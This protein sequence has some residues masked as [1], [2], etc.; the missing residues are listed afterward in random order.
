[1]MRYLGL[2]A[3]SGV[4]V[5]A[6]TGIVALIAYDFVGEDAMRSAW[7]AA[8]SGLTASATAVPANTARSDEFKPEKE[9]HFFEETPIEGTTLSVST[10]AA[11]AS[12]TA[13]EARKPSRQ[14]CYLSLAST[15]EAVVE[16][17]DLGSQYGDTA[18][19]FTSA[20][21]F[22]R[23]NLSGHDLTAERLGALARTHCR[24]GR[25]DPLG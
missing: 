2:A 25:L 6:A 15:S 17:L 24:F 11:Y 4:T 5:V 8:M 3:A 21:S 14:W 19:V 22:A 7:S 1:M 10:G 12:V 9:I 23:A 18:P 20:S 13:V 16:R